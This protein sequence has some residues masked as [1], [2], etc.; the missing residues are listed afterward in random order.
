MRKSNHYRAKPRNQRGRFQRFTR[1][2][3]RAA[4]GSR[5]FAFAILAILVWGCRGASRESESRVQQGIAMAG[6]RGGN[7]QKANWD[8]SIGSIVAVPAPFSAGVGI[9]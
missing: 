6:F 2:A 5:A 4:G 7:S 3:A 1:A 8:E 9:R